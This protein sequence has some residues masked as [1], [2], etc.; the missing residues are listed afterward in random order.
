MAFPELE[1]AFKLIDTGSP[2]RRLV[3]SPVTEGDI[4]RA[5]GILGV[6]LPVEYREFVARYGYGGVGAV[7]IYGIKDFDNIESPSPPNL[8]GLN[9]SERAYDLPNDIIVFQ[10]VGN[11]EFYGFDLRNADVTQSQV[12]VWRG[13]GDDIDNLEVAAESFGNHLLAQLR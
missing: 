11:G 7:E 3:G 10:E 6:S 2:K 8:I 1:Q 12:I 9:L 13:G 4:T 5:E